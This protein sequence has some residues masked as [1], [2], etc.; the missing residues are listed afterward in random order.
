[1]NVKVNAYA[2][3][4]TSSLFVCESKDTV[5]QSARTLPQ[6]SISSGHVV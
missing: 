2:I 1:M 4:A 5:K 6:T 3:L